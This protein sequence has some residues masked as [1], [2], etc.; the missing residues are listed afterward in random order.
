MAKKKKIVIL[1]CGR[2]GA[3]LA[4]SLTEAGHE[5]IVIDRNGDQFRRLGENFP[6]KKVLGD[7]LD[8]DV[9]AGAGI[10]AAD[11]FVAATDGDNTNVMSA[12]V[13]C[14]KFNVCRSIVRMYD[15]IRAGAYREEFGIN[16]VCPTEIVADLI[17][18]EVEEG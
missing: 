9:L 12:Q 6:G 16:T 1:G 13:A 10:E 11:V 18:R 14:R 8:I 2:V 4:R 15:P 7:G 3:R 17:Q 5:V